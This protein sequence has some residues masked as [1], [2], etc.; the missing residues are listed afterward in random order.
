MQTAQKWKPDSLA[1]TSRWFFITLH[2]R[3]SLK[4][5][6]HVNSDSFL[7]YLKFH[8][9]F[10]WRS[11]LNE[12]HQEEW[13]KRSGRWRSALQTG[14]IA[15]YAFGRLRLGPLGGPLLFFSS[16]FFRSETNVG[17]FS[18]SFILALQDIP[19]F[20]P[21]RFSWFWTKLFEPLRS[22]GFSSFILF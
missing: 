15:L 1:S 20:C 4:G 21:L 10:G 17:W 13:L 6:E 12:L 14:N 7:V 2:F 16:L 3:N 19:L 5:R 11:C 18:R 9:S 8:P 22:N